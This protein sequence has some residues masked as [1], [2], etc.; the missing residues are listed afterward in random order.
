MQKHGEHAPGAIAVL[1]K[2]WTLYAAGVVVS[3]KPLD[4]VSAVLALLQ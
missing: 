1:V 4:F 3:F 2:C